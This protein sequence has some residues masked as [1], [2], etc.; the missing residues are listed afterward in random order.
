MVITT[1][2]TQLILPVEKVWAKRVEAQ[3]SLTVMSENHKNV[4]G[5][6]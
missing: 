4:Y 6:I 2:W 5:S 3:K 1:G